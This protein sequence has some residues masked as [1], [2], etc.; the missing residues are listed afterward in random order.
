MLTK[1]FALNPS[2][3]VHWRY[4]GNGGQEAGVAI[5]PGIK[6]TFALF[7]DTKYP[8]TVAFPLNV[9]F[10]CSDEFQ[11]GDSGFGYF[12]GGI[13]VSVP[14]AFIPEKFGAWAV[15]GSTTYYSTVH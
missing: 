1:G 5:V 8:L 7:K 11:G 12:S 15:T 4:E 9:A 2:V 3:N 10:F 6:P 14:L 13:S